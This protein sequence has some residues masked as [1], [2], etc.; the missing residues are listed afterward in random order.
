MSVHLRQSELA[1]RWC[2][3]P[4]TLERWRYT[5][6]GPPY[7][8]IGGRVV[9]RLADIEDFEDTSLETS[10]SPDLADRLSHLLSGGKSREL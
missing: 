3:S 8:R 6:K 2:L 1:E 5:G 9:Y 4:R 10:G 7:L